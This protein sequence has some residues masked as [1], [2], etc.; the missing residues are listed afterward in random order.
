MS[1][2]LEVLVAE[3]RAEMRGGFELVAERIANAVR[4]QG[5]ME[6]ANDAEHRRLERRIHA[7]E[8]AVEEYRLTKARLAG[9]IGGGAVAGSFLGQAVSAWFTS[10]TRLLGAS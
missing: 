9:L 5:R 7:N 3:I 10:V 4:E 6:A 1:S 2:D 8:K